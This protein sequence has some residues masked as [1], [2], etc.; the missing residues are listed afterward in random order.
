MMATAEKIREIVEMCIF[1]APQ[2]CTLEQLHKVFEG[3]IP[4]DELKAIADELV[5]STREKAVM[6][7]EVAAGY[8]MQTNPAYAEYARRLMGDAK[9]NALSKAAMETLSIIAYKQPVNQAEID[10]IR[11]KNS[12]GVLVTLVDKGLIKMLGRAKDPGRAYLYGTTKE[13]LKYLRLNSLADL[14]PV[15]VFSP[16]QES[17]GM[18]R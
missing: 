13:F 7:V 5:D 18:T 6:V 9:E 16:E 10:A 2:P 17:G 12:T 15:E 14:P 4:K 1:I 11:G 8:Q 3:K